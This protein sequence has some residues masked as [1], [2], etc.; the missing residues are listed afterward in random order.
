[1]KVDDSQA[2]ARALGAPFVPITPTFP[3]LGPLGLVPLP[4][5]WRI[6]FCEPI[7]LS[8]HPPDAAEDRGLVLDISEQVRETIQGKVYENLVA[9]GGAFL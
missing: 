4:S 2:L 1:P 5:K 6:E 7:D 3:W 8:E 9:R